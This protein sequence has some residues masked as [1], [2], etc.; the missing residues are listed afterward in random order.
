MSG[1]SHPRSILNKFIGKDQELGWARINL[2]L[3][4]MHAGKKIV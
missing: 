4:G 2:I 1:S 3:V